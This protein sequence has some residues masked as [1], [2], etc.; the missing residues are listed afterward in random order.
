MHT[1]CKTGVQ[2][3][4]GMKLCWCQFNTQSQPL[5]CLLNQIVTAMQCSLVWSS[6]QKR[7]M[8]LA[9][10]PQCHLCQFSSWDSPLWRRSWPENWTLILLSRKIMLPNK[11]YL[12]LLIQHQALKLFWA[13]ASKF[14]Q[15]HIFQRIKLISCSMAAH[16]IV[17]FMP[18]G[19]R[20]FCMEVRR[21]LEQV[22]VAC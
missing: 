10:E 13:G 4:I 18:A 20:S 8:P 5:C 14:M 1:S 15:L 2:K 11:I 7:C 12:Q 19:P 17:N 3:E 22:L 16:D 21:D 6:Q 9:I